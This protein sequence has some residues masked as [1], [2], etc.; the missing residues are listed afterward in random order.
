MSKKGKKISS[1]KQEK[2][3]SGSGE[4]MKD[5]VPKMTKARK[6]VNKSMTK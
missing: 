6:M 1:G 4:H 3:Q 2:D 5:M